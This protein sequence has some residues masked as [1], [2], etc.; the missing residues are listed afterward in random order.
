MWNRTVVSCRMRRG[1]AFGSMLAAL[2]FFALASHTHSHKNYPGTTTVLKSISEESSQAE[3]DEQVPECSCCRP[4][5]PLLHRMQLNRLSMATT[6]VARIQSIAHDPATISL[7][8]CD[9]GD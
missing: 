8:L 4:T 3:V 1:R 7:V 5:V 9:A 2:L 6:A